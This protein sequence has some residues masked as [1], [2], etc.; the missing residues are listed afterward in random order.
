MTLAFLLGNRF[1]FRIILTGVFA[2]GTPIPRRNTPP[3]G[4]SNMPIATWIIRNSELFFSALTIKAMAMVTRPNRAAEKGEEN[5][6]IHIKEVCQNFK[7]QCVTQ[8]Q[9]SEK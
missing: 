4:P 5:V 7:L 2:Q 8:T 9:I 1:K 3:M 6:L